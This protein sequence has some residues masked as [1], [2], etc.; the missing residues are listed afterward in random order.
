MLKKEVL[1]FTFSCYSKGSKYQ[2]DFK[3]FLCNVHGETGSKYEDTDYSN[4]DNFKKL[5]VVAQF[6]G[7]VKKCVMGV[8]L[9]CLLVT[10][11]REHK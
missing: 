5:S 11:T 4:I 1:D 2:K 9:E 8:P 6:L 7:F 3:T 10:F